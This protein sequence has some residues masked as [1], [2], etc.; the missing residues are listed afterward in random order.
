MWLSRSLWPPTA[1]GLGLLCVL[2][3]GVVPDGPSTGRFRSSLFSIMTSNC[4][5]TGSNISPPPSVDSLD[6]LVLLTIAGGSIVLFK[7]PLSTLFCSYFGSL[8]E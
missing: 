2:D 7:L 1:E 5:F 4:R 3:P 6:R 8:M